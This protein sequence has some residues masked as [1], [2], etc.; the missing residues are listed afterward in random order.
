MLVW[1]FWFGSGKSKLAPA[2]GWSLAH[3]RRA[4][5]L[6]ETHINELLD[7]AANC[8][9]RGWNDDGTAS[10]SLLP[11]AAGVVAFPTLRAGKVTYARNLERDDTTVGR[12]ATVTATGSVLATV[13]GSAALFVH[14]TAS[15]A[16]R[17]SLPFNFAQ[18]QRLTSD[19]EEL[20]LTMTQWAMQRSMDSASATTA[21]DSPT[22]T[23]RTAAASG[24]T[25]TGSG[26]QSLRGTTL[27]SNANSR[28]DVDSNFDTN[29]TTMPLAA[30]DEQA[31][32]LVGAPFAPLTIANATATTDDSL[33]INSIFVIVL[34]VSAALIVALVVSILLVQRRRRL[35][36]REQSAPAT[37][38]S[39]RSI[40]SEPPTMTAATAMTTTAVALTPTPTLLYDRV[41]AMPA[42][43]PLYAAPTSTLV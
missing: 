30:D 5:G 38:E 8:S 36:R 13:R 32:Q 14:T 31:E 4:R 7:L 18:P 6:A 42:E 11:E 17:V 37:A 22:T 21:A 40:A 16:R 29:D 39:M 2:R 20:L 33:H 27:S 3:A 19:G 43:E 15:G 28:L 23:R 24:S 25:A 10:V 35:R 26:S 9:E 1:F 41:I 12:C 34:A